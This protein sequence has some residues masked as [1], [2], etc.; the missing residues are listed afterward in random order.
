MLPILRMG[1]QGP[2]Y[3]DDSNKVRQLQ[4]T[5]ILDTSFI[6][7]YILKYIF[8]SSNTLSIS[9][10]I[11]AW[12]IRNMNM[13]MNLTTVESINR[14]LKKKCWENNFKNMG[15]ACTQF[16]KSRK[17]CCS[18]IQA[19][20]FPLDGVEW[21]AY[22]Y[23]RI[24]RGITPVPIEQKAGWASELVHTIC[25]CGIISRYGKNMGWVCSKMGNVEGICA[26][27]GGSNRKLETG[28]SWLALLIGYCKGDK[29]K[30][31]EMGGTCGTYGGEENVIFE[32]SMRRRHV[33]V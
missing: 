23:G 24:T 6:H 31:D 10:Y 11:T 18:V 14:T 30:D 7:T 26:L 12:K 33:A 29:I 13:N 17:F 15:T 27:E 20:T 1:V 19:L 32:L 2:L 4:R 5:I 21:S 8:L 28:A 16:R 9:L 22:R 3:R 25:E